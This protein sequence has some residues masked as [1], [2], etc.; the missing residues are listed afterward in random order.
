MDSATSISCPLCHHTQIDAFYC[1]KRRDYLSCRD[2]NL[3]FV[4]EHQ[5]L[6]AAEEKAIYDLHQNHT[7]DEGYRR[8]LSRLS[9][10]LTERLAQGATGLDF[11]C[12]PASALSVMLQEQGFRMHEYDPLYANQPELLQNRYDFVTCTEVVEHFRN[13][14]T[15]IHRLFSLLKN[16]GFLG[17]MTKRVIDANAFARWHYKND[18]TH[19]SFFSIS[20]FKWLA[21]K[22]RCRVEFFSQDVAIFQ[23]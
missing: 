15:D 1:D 8:F 7:D 20:T 19:I 17:I 21:H 6:S 2:C 4:P 10:P 13:P 14:H 23:V 22:Y 3:V 18:L 9:T 16:G 5:H 11:G 12:G